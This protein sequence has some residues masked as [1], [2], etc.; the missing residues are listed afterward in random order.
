MAGC[1]SGA[2]IR[3][4]GLADSQVE[5]AN[6]PFFP[7][8]RYQCG[9]AALATV[10]VA[11]GVEVNPQTLAPR[12]YLPERRGSLQADLVAATRHYGRVP[13]VI[14]ADLNT[15]LLEIANGRPVLVMQNLALDLFPQWH[16][17]VVVGYDSK[18]D[19]LLLRS[20]VHERLRISRLRFEATWA[21]AER[22]A[23]VAASPSQPPVTAGYA[24]WLLAASAFEELEQPQLAE[25]AYQAATTRWPLDVMAWQA[26]ANA[27]YA[28]GDLKG[29][30][31]ALRYA[32]RLVPSVAAHN[33]LAHVLLQQGCT[34]EALLALQ[35]ARAMDVAGQFPRVLASTESAI[36]MQRQRSVREC[37]LLP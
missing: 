15:L 12:V 27:R 13:Y 34:V 20:G 19:S 26:L 35:Q 4:Y 33:N 7:Q 8:T 28:Q 31:S 9:P 23:M 36:K 37:T 17:A 5:L 3:E 2:L 32:I 21:R 11:S 24:E 30:E 18:T 29:A 14:A 1:S 25:K 16:Y 22:W 6:T 10:L